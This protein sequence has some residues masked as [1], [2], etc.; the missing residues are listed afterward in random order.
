MCQGGVLSPVLFNVYIDDIV[1]VISASGIGCHL[2]NVSL[3]VLIY[4][5]YILLLAPTVSALQR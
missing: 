3:A 2:S 5:D 1:S 4:A